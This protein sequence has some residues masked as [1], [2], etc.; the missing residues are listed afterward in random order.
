MPIL[1]KVERKSRASRLLSL[2]IHAILILGGITMIYPFLLLVSGSLKSSV[3]MQDFTLIPQ[4][5]VNFREPPE[6][7][8]FRKYVYT[9]YNGTPSE[10]YAR[11]REDPGS[12]TRLMPPDPVDRSPARIAD[13]KAFLEEIHARR[14]HWWRSAGSAIEKGDFPVIAR[15]YR[16]WLKDKYGRGKNDIANLNQSAGSDFDSWGSVNPP[17]EK[18]LLRTAVTNYSGN[19]ALSEFLDFKNDPKLL[20][21]LNTVYNDAETV[22]LETLRRQFGRTIAEVNRKLGTQYNSWREISMPERIPADPRLAKA[23][24]STVRESLNPAFSELDRE[25]ESYWQ[26]YLSS[27]YRTIYDFNRMHASACFDFRNIPLP[28][29]QPAEG[30]RLALDWANFQGSAADARFLRVRTLAN[31]YREWLRAKYKTVDGMNRVY[32]SGFKKFEE[33]PLSRERPDF[34]VRARDWKDFLDSL[35]KSET[36]LAKY[37]VFDYRNFIEK[38]YTDSKTHRVDYAKLS[39][40]YGR[41]IRSNQEI[42]FFASC[43]DAHASPQARSNFL[44][45]LADRS[46]ETFLEIRNPGLHEEAFRRMLQTRYGTVDRLN[47]AWGHTPDSW[48]KVSPPF[49]EYDW[50]L[51]LENKWPLI[52][53]Y[54]TRNY[55]MVFDTLFLS[56]SAALNTLIYCLLAVLTTLIVNPL[57]A[58]ALSRHRP[59]GTYK[60]IL[61]LMLPMAIPP[62]VIAIPQFI[63][64]KDL[65]L[66][67][68]FAALILPTMAS[69]YSVFLLKGFFDSLPRELYES[70]AIDGAGEWVVF[71]HITI[72]LSAPILAV[73][74]LGAF[75]AAYANF[76]L[77][78]LLC[79]DK[80]M[81]TMMVYLFQLQ[82]YSSQ[83]VGFAAL[84]VAAVPTLLVFIFC[85]N[86]IIKGIV[87][88][89]EK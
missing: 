26:S 71:W 30:E 83:A 37:A 5:L 3:D 70:A 77:A 55:A 68:T 29:V 69:G 9:K 19:R 42:P 87:V 39:R 24:T 36:A 64:I 52:R 34:F 41:T 89:S 79:Q 59:A 81:W 49:K 10:A 45:F 43:P 22:Y 61:F 7:M 4:Y 51:T 13:F 73:L 33:V 63:L 54:L 60:I 27:Q 32:A 67:N 48:E 14:P 76:M 11:Y 75:T 50:S 16:N 40:D 53:E 85:Q 65:G 80:S 58:Y 66:L 21:R 44:A 47:K 15:R 57:C 46:S 17:D 62:M 86:I 23:W 25:A 35:P 88:P 20:D 84:L 28:A 74:A 8:L 72:R 12:I 31:L 82:Q 78:F 2:G 18:L 6:N 56:G 38:L 1:G